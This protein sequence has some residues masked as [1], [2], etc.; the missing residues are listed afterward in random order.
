MR[1]ITG[2]VLAEN[3]VMID[4]AR[5]LGFELHSADDEPGAV[6]LTLK[7]EQSEG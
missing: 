7:I 3:T 5:K 2:F 4:M 1:E 6:Q